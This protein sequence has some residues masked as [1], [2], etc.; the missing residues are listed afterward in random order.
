M[1]NQYFQG[2]CTSW[3][4]TSWLCTRSRAVRIGF[5]LAAVGV[6]TLFLYRYR[7]VMR[8]RRTGSH[9]LGIEGI[10]SDDATT[11]TAV[12]DPRRTTSPLGDD[13]LAAHLLCKKHAGWRI[14]IDFFSVANDVSLA[15]TEAGGAFLRELLDLKC[16]VFVYCQIAET[17]KERVLSALRPFGQLGLVRDRVLFCTT[18][19]AHEAFTRQLIPTLL[20]STHLETVSAVARHIPY[21]LMVSETKQFEAS[22][23]TCVPSISTLLS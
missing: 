12:V 21:V 22:N 15:L 6:A 10:D 1:N 9:A 11:N 18:V 23:V 14:S 17:D 2:S 16:E 3:V 4:S 8:R 19:K 20:V 5:A 13:S 7:L